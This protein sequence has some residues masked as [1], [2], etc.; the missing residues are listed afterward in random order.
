MPT[1][2]TDTFVVTGSA[3]A[4]LDAVVAHHGNL[5]EWTHHPES[6]SITIHLAEGD[7]PMCVRN[8]IPRAQLGRERTPTVDSDV[9]PEFSPD[10]AFEFADERRRCWM[11]RALSDERAEVQLIAWRTV[12]DALEASCNQHEDSVAARMRLDREV[13]TALHDG[14]V[15]GEFV[16]AL[17]RAHLETLDA[18][19]SGA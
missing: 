11:D 12:S 18:G 14:W 15:T 1:Y 6:E 17:S 3:S 9:E 16:D 8:G 19:Y 13:N 4:V 7:K 5:P 2:A 10:A